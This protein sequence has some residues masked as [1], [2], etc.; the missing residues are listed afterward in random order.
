MLRKTPLKRT[1]RPQWRRKAEDAVSP[2]VGNFVAARDQMC[3]M[4]MLDREHDCH[5][6]FGNRIDPRGQYELDHID[7]G[8]TGKRGPS[9]A[10]NLVRLC[11]YAHR[12]KTDNARLWRPVFRAYIERVE[13]RAA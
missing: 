13:G 4:A 2:A 11:P 6:Q 5:D 3:V 9:T 8:G 12:I 7:N 10:S 1:G